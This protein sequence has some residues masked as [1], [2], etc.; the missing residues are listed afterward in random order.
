[1]DCPSIGVLELSGSFTYTY[2]L[3]TPCTTSSL[4]EVSVYEWVCNHRIARLWRLRLCIHRGSFELCRIR[5]VVAGTLMMLR[6]PAWTRVPPPYV[7]VSKSM[8]GLRA[9]WSA[10]PARGRTGPRRGVRPRRCRLVVMITTCHFTWA[11]SLGA[12][13]EVA[14]VTPAKMT[15]V[16]PF[17]PRTKVAYVT[18]ATRRGQQQ[19]SRSGTRSGSL[20]V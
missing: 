15:Q 17:D 16:V 3:E 19:S 14:A 8:S 10:S 9:R 2:L 5:P 6:T 20:L 11:T 12:H 18:Y 7:G 1:L 4:I 13:F